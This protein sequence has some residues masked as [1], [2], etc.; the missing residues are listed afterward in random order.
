[1]AGNGG[2]G[3]SVPTEGGDTEL[4]ERGSVEWRNGMDTTVCNTLNV[5]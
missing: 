5:T 4:R 3:N 1:M 2:S